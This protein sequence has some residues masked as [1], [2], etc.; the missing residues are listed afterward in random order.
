MR[1]GD[2]VNVYDGKGGHKR[3]VVHS[4]VGVGESTFK[5]LSIRVGDELLE[6]VNHAADSDGSGRFWLPIGEHNPHTRSEP[7]AS[8]SEKK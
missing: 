8:K 6:K 5:Q 4:I 7:A 1:A 2:K 3:G